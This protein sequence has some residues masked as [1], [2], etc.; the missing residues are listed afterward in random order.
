M[1]GLALLD[2]S[3]L[4]QAQGRV[5]V[6]LANGWT[7]NTDSGPQSDSDFL[8]LTGGGDDILNINSFCDG[9]R[10]PSIVNR[11]QSNV[12]GERSED[13]PLSG[14]TS[15]STW[16]YASYIKGTNGTAN[17]TA[18]ATPSGVLPYGQ[19]T[20]MGAT[21]RIE[22]ILG[23]FGTTINQSTISTAV[24]VP[25]GVYGGLGYVFARMFLTQGPTISPNFG[26]ITG[27]YY[28]NLFDASANCTL[29][30]NQGAFLNVDVLGDATISLF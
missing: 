25:P 13:P 14:S 24:V 10:G 4:A 30:K 19:K 7:L 6:T 3:A 8:Y 12:Q 2:A 23:V 15:A 17:S 11:S 18:V 9:G 28:S 21:A 26:P 1:L 22:M 29:K 27:F 5:T 20:N 16:A